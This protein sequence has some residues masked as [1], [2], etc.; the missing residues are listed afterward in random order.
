MTHAFENDTVDTWVTQDWSSY[1]GVNLWVY[2]H[3]T[4][5]MLLFEVQ[6]NRNPGSPPPTRKS[7]L[8]LLGDFSGSQYVEIPSAPSPARRS[9]TGRPTTA[10]G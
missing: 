4:G 7:G 2:G 3:N 1:E 6:D 8:Y 5:A 10:S 9:A